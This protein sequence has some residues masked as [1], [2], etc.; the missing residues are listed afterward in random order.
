[1]VPFTH[2]MIS[3][4]DRT[5]VS[6]NFDEARLNMVKSQV[7]PW[8]VLDEPILEVMRLTPREHFVPEAYA[9]LAY[10]DFEIPIGQGEC[11]LPP[12]VLGRALQSLKLGPSD[13]VLEIGTGTG[14]STALISKLVKQLYSLEIDPMLFDLAQRNLSPLGLKNIQLEHQD[15][16]YGWERFAPY[17]SIFVSGAYPKHIPENLGQQLKLGGRAFIFLG[18]APNVQGVLLEKLSASKLKTTRLF[19]TVVP[20][21]KG[22]TMPESFT[23]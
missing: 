20:P 13:D 5:D 2:F 9:N 14:Y 21:L 12:K 23:F 17:D 18:Q 15:G 22:I 16:A 4:E 1:M 7:R 19:E 8:N 10:G 3:I 11:M 6:M